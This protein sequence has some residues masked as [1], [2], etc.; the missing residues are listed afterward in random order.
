[1]FDLYAFR[2]ASEI[3][4]YTHKGALYIN[5]ADIVMWHATDDNRLVIYLRDA[6]RIEAIPQGD[7]DAED[8]FCTVL[9]EAGVESRAEIDRAIASFWNCARDLAE[10]ACRAVED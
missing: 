4:V 10:R 6:R 7:I 5:A 2:N 1:M 8:W 9:G 3:T